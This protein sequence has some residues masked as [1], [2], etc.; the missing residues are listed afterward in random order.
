MNIEDARRLCLSIPETEET[1]PFGDDTVVFKVRG[2]IFAMLSFMPGYSN[3]IS[4]KCDPNYAL[5]L[6]DKHIGAIDG[7][8]HFNK[9]YWNMVDFTHYSIT[10]EFL[11]HLISHSYNE[12]CKKMP[13]SLKQGLELMD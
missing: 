11:F 1:Q 6:R 3:Y 8:Y 9:N 10:E 7:A 12:V 4:L 5:Q 13:K 2:K